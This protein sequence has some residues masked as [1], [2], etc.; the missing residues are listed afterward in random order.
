MRQELIDLLAELES[1]GR[2]GSHTFTLALAHN[3][4]DLDE[5]ERLIDLLNS[6]NQKS[7]EA[8][9]LSASLRKEQ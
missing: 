1:L 7:Q 8:F 6:I 5:W 9:L 2:S 3:D 4:M